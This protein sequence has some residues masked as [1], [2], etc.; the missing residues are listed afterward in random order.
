MYFRLGV[1]GINL[2]IA[3]DN[4]PHVK[5]LL[6]YVYESKKYN[7]FIKKWRT[8]KIRGHIYNRKITR[9]GIVYFELGI[10]WVFYILTVF[11]DY[12]L[13]DDYD[14]VVKE[15]M[16][17]TYRTHPF[18]ILRDDQ[19]E[20]VLYL[21]K[22]KFGLYSCHTGWGKSF[23]IAVLAH[24]FYNQGK[25]I[26]LVTPNKKARDELV[27]RIYNLFGLKVSI[28]LG[29][30]MIQAVITSGLLNKKEMKSE[31]GRKKIIK[32]LETFEVL[33]SDEVEYT[34]NKSGFFIYDHVVGASYR[35]GFSGTADKGNAKMIT[36]AQ[37]IC[38]ETVAE[39]KDLIRY[40]GTSLVYRLPK[41]LVVNRIIIKTKSMNPMKLGAYDWNYDGM[42][43]V[44]L[45]IMNNI[46]T[47]PDVC[48][49]IVKVCKA[50]PLTF[51][52]INNL[53]K[54][55]ST[56]ITEYFVGTFKI[57]LVSHAGYTYYDLEGNK[58]DITLQEA[59][60][61]IKE[62]EVDVIPSTSSGFRALDFPNLKNMLLFSGKVAGSL[63]QQVGRVS[64]QK[65]MNIITL[66][67]ES[68][69]GVIPVYTKGTE[70]RDKM[71]ASYY[72]NCDIHKIV[73]FESELE[74]LN[75]EN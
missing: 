74:S 23:I 67:P 35:Y 70:E 15:I 33:M 2:V 62:G 30:G 14:A 45:E 57:L 26:I 17:E 8:E 3:T 18:S 73:V 65:E 41:S 16:Q 36:T 6:D 10:G 53:V 5:G 63:I 9:N 64:R 7:S 25:K 61:K 66:A 50:Y 68:D 44:Y 27:K 42:S 56:W 43:N 39:N 19:N 48:K 75:N 4:A 59:C 37:G 40:F 54:I 13:K 32:E 51:I 20:D 28:E 34:M 24:D 49:T 46:F 29:V 55:I 38:N 21:L 12:I 22:Y 31:E 60:D 72:K 52:P 58:T 1:F 47:N 11:K 71:I 69:K